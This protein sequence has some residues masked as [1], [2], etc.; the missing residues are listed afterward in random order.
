MVY[1]ALEEMNTK[2]LT[3]EDRDAFKG[4]YWRFVRDMDV[5]YGD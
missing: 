4:K 5:K 1:E 3:R 2:Y